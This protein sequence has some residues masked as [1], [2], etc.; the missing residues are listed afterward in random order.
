[1]GFDVADGNLNRLLPGPGVV[2]G[3]AGWGERER[4]WGP[5]KASKRKS[6]YQQIM[7]VA[8]FFIFQNIIRH[9]GALAGV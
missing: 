9:N 1:M 5:A 4:G 7:F 6:V 8:V 3:G 2:W